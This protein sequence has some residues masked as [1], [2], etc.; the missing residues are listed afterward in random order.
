[1]IRRR[2]LTPDEAMRLDPDHAVVFVAGQ[3]PIYARKRR[4][5]DDGDLLSRA[6][7]PAPATS[8]HAEGVRDAWRPPQVSRRLLIANADPNPGP[9]TPARSPAAR[10]VGLQLD[11]H[12]VE[13][14]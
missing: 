5:F 7:L 2:L 12:T 4:Y 9:S 8:P 11:S 1:E 6:N 13:R 3:Q 10:E 14:G